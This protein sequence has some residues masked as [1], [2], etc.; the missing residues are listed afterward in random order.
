[1]GVSVGWWRRDGSFAVIERVILRFREDGDGGISGG[2]EL[3]TL[4]TGGVVTLGVVG[5]SV[6]GTLGSV[7]LGAG[8]ARM[9]W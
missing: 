9:S 6:V 4:G 8:R 1:M 7:S 5:D 2:L 3:G